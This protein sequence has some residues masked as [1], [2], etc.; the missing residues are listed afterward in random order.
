[1]QA[2][3]MKILS[4]TADGHYLVAVPRPVL[5]SLHPGPYGAGGLGKEIT[6]DP[7]VLAIL[8]DVRKARDLLARVFERVEQLPESV[9]QRM[10]WL[11]NRIRELPDL[12][13]NWEDLKSHLQ[14]LDHQVMCMLRDIQ[15]AHPPPGAMVESRAAPV[16]AKVR[17]KR[18]GRR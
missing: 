11:E 9:D 12:G 16:P 2:A 13:E 14:A 17:P 5:D 8:A 4:E 7:G 6:I 10:R 18:K 1:M 15:A 3:T